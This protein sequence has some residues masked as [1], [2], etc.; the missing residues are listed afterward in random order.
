MASSPKAGEKSQN[1]VGDNASAPLPQG[2]ESEAGHNQGHHFGSRNSE[3]VP[4][5]MLSDSRGQHSPDRNFMAHLLMEENSYMGSDPSTHELREVVSDDDSPVSDDQTELEMTTIAAKEAPAEHAPAEVNAGQ[6]GGGDHPEAPISSEIT[7]AKTDTGAEPESE[8]KSADPT[9]G[10][11]PEGAPNRHL[12]LGNIPLRPNKL[13]IEMLFGAFGAIDSIRVFP[14]KTFAFI[15]YQSM[16]DAVRAKETLDGQ[17]ATAVISGSKPMAIRFQKDTSSAP[18][19]GEDTTPGPASETGRPNTVKK[20]V[21][22]SASTPLPKISANRVPEAVQPSATLQ[23]HSSLNQNNMLSAREQRLCSQ[24]RDWKLDMEAH[25]LSQSLSVMDI[26]SARSQE[27]DRMSDGDLFLRS[28]ANLLSQTSA[29][30]KVSQTQSLAKNDQS[31]ICMPSFDVGRSKRP[32]TSSQRLG[33]YGDNETGVCSVDFRGGLASRDD[34]SSV[35]HEHPVNAPTDAYYT[36]DPKPVDGQ[37]HGNML[38]DPSEMLLRELQSSHEIQSLAMG[39]QPQQLLQPSNPPGAAVYRPYHSAVMPSGPALGMGNLPVIQSSRARARAHNEGPGDGSGD[40][41][42][43]QMLLSPN[44]RALPAQQGLSNQQTLPS[45]QVNMGGMQFQPM[46]QGSQPSWPQG[47]ASLNQ[48]L[49]SHMLRGSNVPTMRQQHAGG[50]HEMR[51]QQASRVHDMGQDQAGGVHNMRHQQAGGVHDTR[52]QHAGGLHSM[53]QQQAGGLRDMRLPQPDDL[54]SGFHPNF[55]LV[56]QQQ[57]LAFL[58]ELPMRYGAESAFPMHAMSQPANMANLQPHMPGQHVQMS[59]LP[60]LPQTMSPE[61]LCPLT[62]FPMTDP[63]MAADGIIYEKEAIMAWMSTSSISPTTGQILVN[64]RLKQTTA[65][66]ST[67]TL[68][69]SDNKIIYA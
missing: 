5:I 34:G 16:E 6:P 29:W 4:T 10:D 30:D 12:W 48:V 67:S 55:R 23:K 68:N 27:R 61:F 18:G 35:F 45:Q 59:N 11:I 9:S 13:A 63:V 49:P 69:N 46:Y 57:I 41:Q 36:G 38:M 15:N 54:G 43:S 60:A 21:A 31:A 51:H 56:N 8:D 53:R 1:Q 2:R 50:V 62:G 26:S 52:Q 14:G 17:S 32:S 42:S 28:S 37:R 39:H 25:L 40:T 58:Q 66:S 24:E 65:Y 3:V 19:A 44:Q 7:D 20:T 22:V 33:A 47:S 64:S